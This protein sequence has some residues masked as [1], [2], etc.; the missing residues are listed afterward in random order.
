MGSAAP[1]PAPWWQPSG[2]LGDRCS[3]SSLNARG[4]DLRPGRNTELAD[5]VRDR[6][7]YNAELTERVGELRAE[8]DRL[9]ADAADAP[10]LRGRLAEVG[11]QHQGVADAVDVAGVVPVGPLDA[12][13]PLVHAV[14]DALLDDDPGRRGAA[15][16]RGQRA[17]HG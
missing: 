12:V 16:Q 1:R 6:S 3:V 14:G 13:G 7:R 2:P 15:L 11:L 17:L 9:A 5:V 10:D 8:V 4:Y